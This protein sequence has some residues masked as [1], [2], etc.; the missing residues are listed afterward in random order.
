MPPL[1]V[2]TEAGRAHLRLAEIAGVVVERDWAARV[3]AGPPSGCTKR[4]RVCGERR[5]REG[6]GRDVAAACFPLLSAGFSSP[7][8]FLFFPF[9]P[10][11][12]CS[13]LFTH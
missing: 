5:A 7:I 3:L 11:V 8:A 4:F 13:E 9:I 1:A 6:G 12:P 10:S 2:Q